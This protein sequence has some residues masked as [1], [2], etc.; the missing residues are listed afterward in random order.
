MRVW[1][2]C[3]IGVVPVPHQGRKFTPPPQFYSP[4]GSSIWGIVPK[5]DLGPFRLQAVTDAAE[6]G[7]LEA[8]ISRAV[9]VGEVNKLLMRSANRVQD[10]RRS[11][12]GDVEA[13]DGEEE[14]DDD[15]EVEP[16]DIHVRVWRVGWVNWC[17][18][19]M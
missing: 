4:G 2:P 16:S 15:D 8:Q 5:C 19:L 17:L 10:A 18:L 7:A 1:D 14:E 11:L 3:P 9:Q 6:A 13:A 12:A